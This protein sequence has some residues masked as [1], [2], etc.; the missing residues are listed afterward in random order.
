M[1]IGVFDVAVSGDDEQ[2][3]QKQAQTDK[4]NAAI[5][6]LEAL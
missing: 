3:I 2:R 5:E 1:A 4:L 6:T